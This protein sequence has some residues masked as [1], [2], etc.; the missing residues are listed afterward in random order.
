M[1][2]VVTGCNRSYYQSWNCSTNSM[3]NRMVALSVAR[4]VARLASPRSCVID[5]TTL[6]DW[7]HD[8]ERPV[9]VLMRFVIAGSEF[10]TWPSNLLRPN[11]PVRS[12]ATSKI[13]CTICQRFSCGSSH[14]VVVS[15]S[16]HGRKPDVTRAKTSAVWTWCCE[17]GDIFSKVAFDAFSFGQYSNKGV[18]ESIADRSVCINDVVRAIELAQYQTHFIW[19]QY[20]GSG[21]F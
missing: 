5:D 1:Q 12:P 17:G 4:P 3:T 11:F 9:C 6:Q 16:Q 21:Q 8:H 2:P 10:W 14:F 15:R 7:S 19:H 20:A 18:V 13:N